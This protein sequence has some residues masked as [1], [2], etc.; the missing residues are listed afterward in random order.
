M[1]AFPTGPTEYQRHTNTTITYK[2]LSKMRMWTDSK[3]WGRCMK[4][5]MYWWLI[6]DSARTYRVPVTDAIFD[7]MKASC[8]G[9][10]LIK[11]EMCHRF[12]VKKK[13]S[14]VLTVA[15]V[16]FTKDE[17]G[18]KTPSMGFV[19]QSKFFKK[20]G[21]RTEWKNTTRGDIGEYR[22]IEIN[23]TYSTLCG[24]KKK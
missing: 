24:R 9:I 3:Y 15:G 22:E 12:V 8:P 16:D 2:L 6:Y 17:T 14:T 13:W 19:D 5:K 23:T 21:V 10:W 18:G 4:Y 7:R 1:S 11:R 20:L